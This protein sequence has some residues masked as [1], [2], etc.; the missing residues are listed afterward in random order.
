VGEGVWVS[1]SVGVRVCWSVGG[2]VSE[3]VALGVSGAAGVWSPASVQAV[4]SKTASSI[5]AA[6]NSLLDE[7]ESILS[8]CQQVDGH[9][10]KE[11][12]AHLPQGQR[13]PQYQD[14]Q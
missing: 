3:C 10:R 5:S 12:A 6:A 11:Y 4:S 7:D 9:Q 2:E 1:G 8:P 14:C 13:L